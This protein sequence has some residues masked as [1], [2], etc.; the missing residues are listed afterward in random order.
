MDCQKTVRVVTSTLPNATEEKLTA[1]RHA[2]IS[3]PS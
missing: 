2:V 1:E 3:E